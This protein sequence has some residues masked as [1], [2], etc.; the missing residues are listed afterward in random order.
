MRN[1]INEINVTISDRDTDVSGANW[2]G[3]Y[4]HWTVEFERERKSFTVPYYGGSA[5][6]EITEEQA[7]YNC[8]QDALA[9]IQADDFE[10]FCHE[11][12]YE[13]FDEEEYAK[14]K[15]IYLACMKMYCDFTRI[16]VLPC[17]FESE[18]CDWLNNHDI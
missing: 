11:F 9:F 17:G 14:S 2:D 13:F 18:A 3:A 12:G 8:L 7:L 5:V 16:L 10:D 1:R 15:K 6:E 4:W